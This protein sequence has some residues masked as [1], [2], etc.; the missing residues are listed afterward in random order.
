MLSDVNRSEL[1]AA[2][3]AQRRPRNL[4]FGCDLRQAAPP[5]ELNQ[6]FILREPIDVS[7]CCEFL[8]RRSYSST[9]SGVRNYSTSKI[10]R[11][12][13]CRRELP[14]TGRRLENNRG[15]SLATPGA[16]SASVCRISSDDARRI[17]NSS[18]YPL[19]LQSEVLVSPETSF[20]RRSARQPQSPLLR[21]D[22]ITD[23]R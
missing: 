13:G 22:S 19:D 17:G 14:K 21:I 20:C 11:I 12:R 1:E 23:R 15:P 4:R 7:A 3:A 9:T 16:S 10:A 2:S 18:N 5:I 8:S 6:I